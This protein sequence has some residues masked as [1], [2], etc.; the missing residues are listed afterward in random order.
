MNLDRLAGEESVRIVIA[1]AIF[2]IV[3][4]DDDPSPVKPISYFSDTPADSSK[5]DV[6][7]VTTEPLYEV[8]MGRPCIS[9]SLATLPDSSGLIPDAFHFAS[10]TIGHSQGIGESFPNHRSVR[11]RQTPAPIPNHKSGPCCDGT[12]RDEPS[13]GKRTCRD[14]PTL[15]HVASCD[16][17]F[18]TFVLFHSV[19]T[20]VP[21]ETP[22]GFTPGPSKD[23]VAQYLRSHRSFARNR[24][25]IFTFSP[26]L[27]EKPSLNIITGGHASSL[28]ISLP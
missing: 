9:S 13:R 24:C 11:C 15:Q 22:S 26:E 3:S 6:S 12:G 7:S 23:S 28:I 17:C 8:G 14:G 25:S 10:N 18:S 1:Q 27:R 19:F 21:R 5:K 20:G 2:S 16:R 4:Q